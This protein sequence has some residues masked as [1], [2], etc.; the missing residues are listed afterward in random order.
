MSQLAASAVPAHADV[1]SGH[2]QHQLLRGLFFQRFSFGLSKQL[3]ALGELP[4]SVA[5]GMQPVMA[6]SGVVDEAGLAKSQFSLRRLT[7]G[8]R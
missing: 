7:D 4:G 8:R 3:T 2:P 1:D 6:Q 5:I